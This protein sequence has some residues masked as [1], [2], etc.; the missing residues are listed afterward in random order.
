MKKLIITLAVLIILTI[1]TAIISNTSTGF[2]VT[3]ILILAMLKFIGV[4]FYFMEMRK[5]HTF[6][7]A[8]I[9]V[10]TILFLTT[11]LIII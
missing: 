8:I 5:A 4:A 9:L 7:K 2:A 3:A 10:F 1:V 6:W 11:T